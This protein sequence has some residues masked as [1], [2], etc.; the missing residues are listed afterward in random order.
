LGIQ[1]RAVWSIIDTKV[2]YNK[3]V[4]LL[5][6]NDKLKWF[7]LRMNEI[8]VRKEG[9]DDRAIMSCMWLQHCGSWL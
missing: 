3:M 4:N 8:S 2:T 9:K 1:V 7:V 5:E 6:L